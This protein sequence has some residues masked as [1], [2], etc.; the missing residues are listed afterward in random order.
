GR[1]NLFLAVARRRVSD[2]AWCYGLAA[3]D[4]S[5]GRFLLSETD[6]GGLAA[7]I[8][9][10][11]PREILLP[12]AVLDDPEL[13]ILWRETKSAITPLARE[14]LDPASAE[15]RLK[16]HFGVATLDSFGMFSGAEITA[17]GMALFYIE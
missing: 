13:A 17:A 2:T 15:R 5:T 12:D 8:A 6:G 3:I 1:A 9:R 11:E 10:L 16:D 7:E 4:I 14:G